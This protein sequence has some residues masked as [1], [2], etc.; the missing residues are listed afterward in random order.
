MT[1]VKSSVHSETALATKALIIVSS[2][3]QK[4]RKKSFHYVRPHA[5]YSLPHTATNHNT[6][7]DVVM[8]IGKSQNAFFFNDSRFANHKRFLK[9]HVCYLF[10]SLEGRQLTLNHIMRMFQSKSVQSYQ[11][12][13]ISVIFV[14]QCLLSNQGYAV[15]SFNHTSL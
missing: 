8:R 4:R 9:I 10:F 1:P 12:S 5:I 7:F 2:L 15:N 13:S 3:Q 11:F 14:Q 6:N